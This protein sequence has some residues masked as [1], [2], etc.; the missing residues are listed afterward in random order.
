MANNKVVLNNET[1]IDIST[2]TVNSGSVLDGYTFH[3]KNGD[4]QSG[5][6]PIRSGIY[7]TISHK[8]IA[9]TVPYGYYSSGVPVTISEAEKEKIIPANIRNGIDILGVT[10]TYSG[11]PESSVN[12]MLA[13]IPS[14][15]TIC[16]I[17]Y[18]NGYWV[19]LTAG[20]G[21]IRS[22]T[23]GNSWVVTSQQSGGSV[24]YPI[25]IYANG[26]WNTCLYSSGMYYSEN[27]GA[28]WTKNTISGAPDTRPLTYV[29]G[30]WIATSGSMGSWYS[31]NG[32]NMTST[33][34]GMTT[35]LYDVDFR[36]GI[37]VAATSPGI[38]YS[39]SS[40]P[41][42]WQTS[43][44]TTGGFSCIKASLPT[45]ERLFVAG[46][47]SIGLMWSDDGIT[48]NASNITSANIKKIA[49]NG[50]S[51]VAVGNIGILQSDDGKEWSIVETAA[52]FNNVVYA[53]GKWVACSTG[54]GLY[55]S[56]D[57]KSWA[58]SNIA[59]GT[60]YNVKAKNGRFIA[61]GTSGIYYASI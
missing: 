18:G 59:S 41:T 6:I 22:S 27:N 52:P 58:Q 36:D 23:N 48:W 15:Q 57:G 42:S 40:T 46:S 9:A 34:L 29:N 19:A 49:T 32:I 30:Y 53:N 12:W 20:R 56:A 33:G 21:I 7:P 61:C 8:D 31:S 38:R 45:A 11:G 3:D 55:D 60:F 37:W 28:E 4:E 17:D 14:N 10:G 2:D 51:W 54:Y 26:V 43:N 24:N 47:G 39:T 13:V 44:Q 1:L 35:F 5:N 50:S 25:I 16:D